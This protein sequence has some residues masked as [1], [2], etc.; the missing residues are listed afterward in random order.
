MIKQPDITVVLNVYRRTDYLNH[1]INKVY[2]QS[3]KPK[4][5]F[6]W[7]NHH[8]DN[9]DFDFSEHEKRGWKIF[10][11]NF[12]WKYHGRF[13][14]AQ[15]ARTEYVAMFDDD[16]I[17][18][19]KWFE[20]CIK[21]IEQYNCIAGSAGIRLIH[22]G[23]STI[24]KDENEQLKVKHTHDRVGWSNKNEK[25]IEADLVGH[26]SVF[27]KEW[28]KYMWS[29]EPRTWENCEDIQFSALAKIYG[30]IR[31]ICPP[32]P[33]DDIELHGSINPTLGS[34]NKA[35][36]TN[37]D[38]KWWLQRDHVVQYYIDRG[39]KTVNNIVKPD[40]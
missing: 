22:S 6:I 31:T 5:L 26:A 24:Y 32:H 20:N 35:S 34:D 27:K 28:L 8:E 39:W 10:R 25:P 33:A 13:A 3:I 11:N 23:Y 37:A 30:N 29:E 36:Y 14:A 4:D 19:S 12:N 15:L 17:P 18:G 9:Q 38:L 7:V 16:T 1:Q 21:T 40:K 2:E